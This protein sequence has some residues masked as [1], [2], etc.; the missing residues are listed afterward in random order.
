[1]PKLLQTC[2]LIR[3]TD[4]DNRNQWIPATDL[5]SLHILCTCTNKTLDKC[6]R[7]K[8]FLFGEHLFIEFIALFFINEMFQLKKI[9][10]WRKFIRCFYVFEF[11]SCIYR[12]PLRVFPLLLDLLLSALP[13]RC[14]A[15]YLVSPAKANRYFILR[16]RYAIAF[17]NF[18]HSSSSESRL[19]SPTP[20][21]CPRTR[22]RQST[23]SWR[24][25][26]RMWTGGS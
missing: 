15:C 2:P 1:M 9:F 18:F 21:R 12:N 26:A 14:F 5:A 19:S 3:A 25:W 22:M 10:C 4:G 6:H 24:L 16:L 7:M 13:T 17:T 23:S 11:I 20:T 8:C